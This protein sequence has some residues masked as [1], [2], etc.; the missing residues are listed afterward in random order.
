MIGLPFFLLSVVIAL[1]RGK[2]KSHRRKKIKSHCK[3][4]S[5]PRI[6]GLV[7][8]GNLQ[9]AVVI[10]SIIL[11]FCSE[12]EFSD[13]YILGSS[14]R[15]ALFFF[16]FFITY[17]LE[18]MEAI[19]NML[20]FDKFYEP[21]FS[22]SYGDSEYL[23]WFNLFILQ[24]VNMFVFYYILKVVERNVIARKYEL[25]AYGGKNGPACKLILKFML[26]TE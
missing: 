23:F 11:A 24:L 13:V 22:I 3:K 20:L 4:I 9:V 15:Y 2:K 12:S 21:H 26:T 1:N 14:I 18:Y 17:I 16:I 19:L 10:Y 7:K 25:T 8:D 6:V 5:L